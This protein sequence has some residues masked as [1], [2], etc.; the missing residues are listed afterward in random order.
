MFCSTNNSKTPLLYKLG[1]V[2]VDI[3]RERKS[4]KSSYKN[5]IRCQSKGTVNSSKF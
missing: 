4:V 5:K 3:K 2:K 1:R